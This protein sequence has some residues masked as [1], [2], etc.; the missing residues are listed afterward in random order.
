MWSSI[1]G[2]ST[3]SLRYFNV[4]GPRQSADGAYP[5]VIA[6]FFKQRSLGKPMTITGDGKQS[7]DFVN[8]YDVVRANISAMTSKKVGKGEVVNVGSGKDYKM[9]E[10]AKLIG[11]P[12][13][14]IPP[15]LEP[16]RTLADIRLAKKLLGW[17]PT[18]T[19]REGIAELKKLD[20]AF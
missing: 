19:L 20:R 3:V 13:V 16:R 12:I 18:I 2:L 5:L 14:H 9:I 8:V 10:V 17:K 6:Q 1:Y 7:R 11:G 15:R 4:Y